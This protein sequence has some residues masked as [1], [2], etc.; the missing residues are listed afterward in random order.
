M[1]IK[2]IFDIL[3]AIVGLIFLSPLFFLIIILIKA[4][5]KGSIL[6]KQRRVGLRHKIFLIYKFRTMYMNVPGGLLTI[7]QDHRITPIGKFLRQY[8]LDELPQLINVLLGDMSLVGPRPEVEKYVALYPQQ[9]RDLVL[10]VRPG[11]TEWASIKMIDENQ[12]L[13]TITNA[14]DYYINVILP[15]KLEYAMQYAR[16]HNFF[17]DILI[18]LYTLKKVVIR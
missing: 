8:K 7:G 9:V 2:R 15:Q 18:I 14:E 1:I 13:A 17:I 16:R 12:M 4:T 11:I 3:C 10:S 5:S 6:F